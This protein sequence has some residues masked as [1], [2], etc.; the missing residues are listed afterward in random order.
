MTEPLTVILTILSAIVSDKE[1]IFFLILARFS[2]DSLVIMTD[3]ASASVFALLVIC[4]ASSCSGNYLLFQFLNFVVR[5][6]YHT[7]F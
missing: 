1:S 2:S 4:F 3:S 6:I 7:L 5:P